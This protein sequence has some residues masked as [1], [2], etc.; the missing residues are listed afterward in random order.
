MKKH[1]KIAQHY[2]R[3]ITD[4]SKCFF[5]KDGKILCSL[6]E[7]RNALEKMPDDVFN[8]H[9]NKEKSDFAQ[10]LYHIIGDKIL[11]RM[12]EKL[13]YD[14]NKTLVTVSRRINKLNQRIDALAHSLSLEEKIILDR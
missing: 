3:K 9:S 6:I 11:S 7:F 5:C 10:W 8:F 2:L 13:K 1:A 14:K 12:V 4:Q